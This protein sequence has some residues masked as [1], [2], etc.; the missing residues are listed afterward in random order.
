MKSYRDR[1][2][3]DSGLALT[4]YLLLLGLVIGGVTFSIG[5][6]SGTIGTAWRDWAGFYETVAVPAEDRQRSKT[7]PCQKGIDNGNAEISKCGGK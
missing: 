4:E 7:L 5:A 6:F 2:A 1:S 3:N